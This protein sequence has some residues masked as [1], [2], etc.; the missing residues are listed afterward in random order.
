MTRTIVLGE[1]PAPLAGWLA[2]RQSLGQDLHDEVWDG[3][4]HVSPAGHRDH[5]DIDDQ[6]GALLRPRARRVGLW[7]SSPANLGTPTNYRVPDRLYFRHR[8]NTTFESTAAI[9]VEIVSPND[10]SYAKF[11]FYFDHGVEELLV[12]DPARRSVEWYTR[13]ADRFVRADDS[14]LLGVT[15]AQLTDEI[16][17]PA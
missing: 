8:H 4:Y 6:V 1:P 3:E 2:T 10:E 14:S 13:S 12:V 9:V 7:P 17:W 11:G 16:D 5:G 15:E